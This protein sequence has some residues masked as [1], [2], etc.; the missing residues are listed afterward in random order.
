MHFCFFNFRVMASSTVL[1]GS[2]DQYDPQLGFMPLILGPRVY[3][4]NKWSCELLK[5]YIVQAS[6]PFLK[7]QFL[8]EYVDQCYGCNAKL[9]NAKI[10]LYQKCQWKQ[11]N[12]RFKLIQYTYEC[13][14]VLLGILLMTRL[15]KQS[16]SRILRYVDEDV[17]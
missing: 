14:R 12:S 4:S 7:L 1:S 15:V 2:R 8:S 11:T 3:I 5:T 17:G 9:N 13:Y 16:C 10:L 6:F